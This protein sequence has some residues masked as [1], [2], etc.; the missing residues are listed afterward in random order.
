MGGYGCLMPLTHKKGGP[1]DQVVEEI[2]AARGL[3][4]SQVDEGQGFQGLQPSPLTFH[5]TAAPLHPL[6]PR[7]TPPS[8][9]QPPAYHAIPI[10]EAYGVPASWSPW[11]LGLVNLD[12]ILQKKL[13][14]ALI[15]GAADVGAEEGCGRC[16]NGEQAREDGG[17]HCSSH[18]FCSSGAYRGA[19]SRGNSRRCLWGTI[20]HAVE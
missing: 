19:S 12:S 2:S 8:P 9:L 17:K 16:H 5:F 6:L 4:P 1:V 18:D 14:L 10:I 7:C 15:P 20:R 13:R 11:P 3:S